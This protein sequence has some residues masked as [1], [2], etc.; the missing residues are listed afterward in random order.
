MPFV[1][2]KFDFNDYFLLSNIAIVYGI[3][4]FMPKRFSNST[5]LPLFIYGST[6]ACM[7]DNSIGGGIFDLYDIMD[8]PEYSVMD[9]VVYFLYAPFGYFFIYF[10]ELFHLKGMK[11]VVY[12]VLF[13]LLSVA[14][15]WL[16]LLAGVFHYKDSY[17]I[18]YS[19]CIYLFSESSLLLFYRFISKTEND[20]QS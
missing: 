13:S 15:E 10:Y 19:Y 18:Y 1:E 16:Y 6:L 11:T 4:Y 5:S 8:G 20:R 9:F 14:F 3:V 2:N 17:L 7:L 12:I